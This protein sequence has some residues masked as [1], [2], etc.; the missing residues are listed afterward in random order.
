ME[1]QCLELRICLETQQWISSFTASLVCGMSASSPLLEAAAAEDNIHITLMLL[2]LVKH[3]DPL[4]QLCNFVGEFKAAIT[5]WAK[6]ERRH[7]GG[8]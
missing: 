2:D 5:A 1:H 3:G 7:G 6:D 4:R 8:G